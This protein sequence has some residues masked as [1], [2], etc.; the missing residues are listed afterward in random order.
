MTVLAG[1]FAGHFQEL[2]QRV[3]VS[4][5]AIFVAT[6]TAYFFSEQVV[7]LFMA[8]LRAAHPEL[9]HLV[10]TSLPEAFIGYLKVSLLVGIAV[11]FPVCLQQIWAFI[12]PG[13]HSHEK[14]I[15]RQVVFWG[16]SLFVAGALFAWLVVL[17][18]AL[19]FLLGFAG[20]QLVPMLRLDDYLTFVGRA[21]LSFG[22][23][24][25]IPFLMVM[26][27]RIGIVG[28]GY[29]SKRRKYFYL[30]I[31][32]LGFLLAGGDPVATLL[33]AL[34][35]FALYEAGLLLGRM[36]GGRKEVPA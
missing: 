30:A 32:V 25:E 26:A 9:A 23:A 4:F 22:L 19:G 21:T 12:A 20:E 35:L 27:M 17:P 15:A 10:Y 16:S 7:R 34:P 3:L 6:A 33:L 2:R 1:H 5:V 13:L 31:L 29:F 28:R 11:S 8:P 36:L 14:R 18:R 24:F